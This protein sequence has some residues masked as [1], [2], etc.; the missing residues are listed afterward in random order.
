ML[1]DSQARKF[2]Y[3][4]LSLTEA[5]NFA[6]HYCLPEGYAPRKN[7]SPADSEL[8]LS[9]IQ[10]VLMGFEQA[11]FTKVRF[12]GGEPTLR[13]DLFPILEFASTLRGFKTR[14]LTTNGWNLAREAVRL[15]LAG[16]QAL[17]VSVDSLDRDR[18]HRLTGRDRLHEVLNGVEKSLGLGFESVKLNA[19]LHQEHVEAELALFLDYVKSRPLTVRFIELMRTNQGADY[20]DR[21]FLS[22]G[23]IRLQLLRSGWEPVSRPTH[24]GPALEFRHPDFQGRIGLIAPHSEGFC[25]TCNRLRVSAT[26]KLRLCLFA[27]GGHDLRPFF[28]SP[29]SAARLKEELASLL[30]RKAPTHFLHEEKSGDLSGFS[31][32][33]G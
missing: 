14:A 31:E 21:H 7:L 1:F 23:G 6:C 2:S 26:G 28:E 3:L 30:Q 29:A 10:N 19:V 4:R 20:R 16:L 32:I 11:G 5:C 27:E 22:S 15:R 13:R 8:T 33:G 25:E 12:T 24:A 17:N 18:F 9:E